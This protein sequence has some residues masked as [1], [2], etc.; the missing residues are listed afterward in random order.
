MGKFLLLIL[1]TLL[2]SD[3][4]ADAMFRAASKAITPA[5]AAWRTIAKTNIPKTAIPSRTA[6]PVAKNSMRNAS[7]MSGSS[8]Q[9]QKFSSLADRQALMIGMGI[10]GAGAG[11]HVAEKSIA[12]AKQVRIEDFYQKLLQA[13]SFEHAKKLIDAADEN[14]LKICT[15][16][17][18]QNLG[19]T[20]WY[21]IFLITERNPEAAKIFTPK[22]AEHF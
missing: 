8:S 2:F 4:P 5:T 9:I 7:Q 12:T 6:L 18:A 22:A 11:L 17:I 20:A 16:K 1:T 15:N 19:T 14:T 10:I 3:H 21:V 13:N